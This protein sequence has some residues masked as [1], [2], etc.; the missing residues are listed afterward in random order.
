MVA[1]VRHH[2]VAL[3]GEGEALGAV[4]GAAQRVHVG[5]EWPELVKHLDP[6]LKGTLEFFGVFRIDLELGQK[7]W[8][9]Y[10]FDGIKGKCHKVDI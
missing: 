3:G 10:G 2:D 4:Q 6:E 7:R 1:A 5:E 8:W 9:R